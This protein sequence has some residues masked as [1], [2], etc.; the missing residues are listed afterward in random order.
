MKIL[1]LQAIDG[2]YGCTIKVLTD[3]EA[4]A[5]IAKHGRDPFFVDRVQVELVD[6]TEDGVHI[7][8]TGGHAAEKA[9]LQKLF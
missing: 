7:V 1:Y 8:E 2:Y 3:A 6:M 5:F 4:A 9:V